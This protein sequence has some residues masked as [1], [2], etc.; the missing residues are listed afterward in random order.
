VTMLLIPDPKELK[1]QDGTFSISA[2]TLIIVPAD[3]DDDAYSVASQIQQE[4]VEAT[5]IS[6]PIIKTAAAPREEDL[7]VLIR[8]R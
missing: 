6:P 5:A 8:G 7:I 3:A 4:I 1:R 2:K